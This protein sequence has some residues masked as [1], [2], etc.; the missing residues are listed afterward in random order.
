VACGISVKFGL[1]T[2]HK[3]LKGRKILT[4]GCPTYDFTYKK[5]ETLYQKKFFSLQ[6]T[7]LAES[8]ECLHSS[9]ALLMPDLRLHKA[10]C[11]PA[12]LARNA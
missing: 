4:F 8:F 1:K 10:T 2:F 3:L 12:V 5:Y 7:R 9:L 6:T 11:D